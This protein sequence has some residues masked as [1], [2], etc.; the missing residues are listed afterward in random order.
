MADEDAVSQGEE[1][2]S[3]PLPIAVAAAVALGALISGQARVSAALAE[4]SDVENAAW[5]TVV[6]GTVILL[7]VLALSARTRLGVRRVLSA[8]RARSLPWWAM[9]G[10]LC[11]MFFV[12]TQGSAAGVLGLALFGMSVVAG[13]VVGGLLFDWAGLAGGEHRRPTTLRV[14]GSLLAI[15]AVSFGAVAGQGAK[16]DVLLIAMAF[17]AGVGLALSAAVTGRVNATAEDPPAAGLLNHLVGVVVIVVLLTVTT[18]GDLS[19]FSL[20]GEPWLYIGGIIG[21]IGV[22]MTAILVRRLGVLLLGLGMVAGQLIGALVL[23]LVAPTGSGGIQVASVVGI[24]LTLAAVGL[25]SLD[26][27]VRRVRPSGLRTRE[28]PAVE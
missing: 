9:V 1:R 23:E 13:Q 27:R 21:P 24:V 28:A 22:A 11:G 15:A 14:L 18:P 26:G 17:T 25:T 6:V 7:V 8:L 3:V 5:V 16:V 19:R 4:R 12:V 2:R 10:G 20:P